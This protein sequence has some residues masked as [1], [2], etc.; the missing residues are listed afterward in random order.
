[1]H[2]ERQ[3]LIEIGSQ[4]GVGAKTVTALAGDW[5]GAY[6]IASIVF[7]DCLPEAEIH[8]KSAD[9]WHVVRGTGKIIVGGELVNGRTVADNELVGSEIAGGTIV[10]VVEGDVVDIPPGVPH[11][12][13]ARGGR[14]EMMIVKVHMVSSSH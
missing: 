9:V 11:Q 6:M 10:S 13:D 2:I 4:S 3:K 1:V 12:I 14:L 7:D 8:K 5:K